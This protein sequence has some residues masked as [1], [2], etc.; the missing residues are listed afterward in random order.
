MIT[1]FSMFVLVLLLFL[2]QLWKQNQMNAKPSV[3]KLI[4]WKV[5]V[6][7]ILFFS[8]YYWLHLPGHFT[9]KSALRYYHYSLMGIPSKMSFKYSFF[10]CKRANMLKYVNAKGFGI[11]SF[12][13]DVIADGSLCKGRK[14]TSSKIHS[15]LKYNWC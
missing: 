2:L 9:P 12:V 7:V 13:E 10:S 5:R 15:Q 6:L 14:S 1:Q 4:L 8:R 11:V 3:K